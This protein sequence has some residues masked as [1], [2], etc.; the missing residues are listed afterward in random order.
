MLFERIKARRIEYNLTQQDLANRAGV[1]RSLISF[2]EDGTKVPSVAVLIKLAKALNVS[3]DWL[4][5]LKNEGGNS[6]GIRN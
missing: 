1:N 6:N 3:T 2:I 4:L 5:G